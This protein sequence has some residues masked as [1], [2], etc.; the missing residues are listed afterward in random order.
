[1]EVKD[2][3]WRGIELVFRDGSQ[4][5][6]APVDGLQITKGTISFVERKGDL[7]THV[8]VERADLRLYEWRK[9]IL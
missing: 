8:A 6:Y 5:V 3:L 1:M 2:R 4:R 9:P 7:E